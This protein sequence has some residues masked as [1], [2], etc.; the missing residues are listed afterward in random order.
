MLLSVSEL[1]TNKQ[2]AISGAVRGSA[3]KKKKKVVETR[4]KGDSKNQLT[5]QLVKADFS[6][7]D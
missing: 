7:K 4:T 5:K 1:K 2:A 6:R 3:E